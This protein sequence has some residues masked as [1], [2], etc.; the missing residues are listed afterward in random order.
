[1]LI[2]AYVEWQLAFASGTTLECLAQNIIFM[3]VLESSNRKH[4]TEKFA[5]DYTVFYG[6]GTA[7]LFVR[8]SYR[9]LRGQSL[10]AIE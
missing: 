1:V 4:V 8:E 7:I 5:N 10:L 6:K 3:D 9:Q 2:S